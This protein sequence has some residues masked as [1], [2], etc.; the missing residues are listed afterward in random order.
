MIWI[1]EGSLPSGC[2]LETVTLSHHGARDKGEI[3]NM[4][5]IFTKIVD[6]LF[7][8]GFLHNFVFQN[9]PL[10]YYLSWLPSFCAPLNWAPVASASLTSP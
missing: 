7:I 4:Y 3:S 1:I 2:G 10:I 8:T 9:I 5:P 6:S